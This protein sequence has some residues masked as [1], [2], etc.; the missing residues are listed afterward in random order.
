MDDTSTFG[1]FIN[2]L[3]TSFQD[4][5]VKLPALVFPV[6]SAARPSNI[7]VDDVSS[8]HAFILM[9]FSSYSRTEV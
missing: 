4:E 3:L 9:S 2:S 1:S 8:S 6:L 5:F 7:D